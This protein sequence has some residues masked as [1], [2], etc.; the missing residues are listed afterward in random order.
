MVTWSSNAATDVRPRLL[1]SERYCT[2]DGP[3]SK[4]CSVVS[5]TYPNCGAEIPESE[6]ADAKGYSCV[7]SEAYARSR[8]SALPLPKY[9]RRDSSTSSIDPIA[10]WPGHRVSRLE[11]VQFGL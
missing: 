2:A 6:I 4:P 8:P 3:A 7:H 10:N 9:S 1:S 5:A 11:H